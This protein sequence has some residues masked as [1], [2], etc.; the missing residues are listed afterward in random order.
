[1]GSLI[2]TRTA[3]R[4]TASSNAGARKAP[5]SCSAASRPAGGGAFY[6]PTVL[7][8]VDNS[9]AVAQEEIFGPVVTVI[10]FED[11]KDA[12]RIAND[13]STGSSRPSGRATRARAPPR[14]ADQGGNGRHQHAVHRFPG[15][16][17]G[18]YKQSGLRP[19]ARARDARAL[20]RDEE[21]A[22]LDARE[23]VQPVRPLAFGG[24]TFDGGVLAARGG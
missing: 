6:P 8:K 21:R 17:F 20:P 2:S 24:W 15:I 1:M 3:T 23:A 13:S 19:R 11:E 22:R 4:C 16:P 9:M 12:A 7:A 10:P 18:G 14:P 5:R